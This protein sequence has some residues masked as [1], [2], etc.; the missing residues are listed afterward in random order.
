[1][2]TLLNVAAMILI[3]SLTLATPVSAD[4]GQ[5]VGAHNA[6]S[7]A[8]ARMAQGVPRHPT[9]EGSRQLASKLKGRVYWLIYY[10]SRKS[11]L[12]GDV[13]VFV[14]ASSGEVIDIYR[15]R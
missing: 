10:R 2:K 12:G 8:N 7:I 9:D 3:A 15:G 6:I 1:M 11:E 4:A 14:D 5:F 13:A